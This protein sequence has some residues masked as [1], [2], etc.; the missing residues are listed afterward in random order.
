MWSPCICQRGIPVQKSNSPEGGKVHYKVLLWGHQM[1]E[2][3][4]QLCNVERRAELLQQIHV[5]FLLSC[6]S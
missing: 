2:G 6:I 1:T 5:L 3:G 4:L